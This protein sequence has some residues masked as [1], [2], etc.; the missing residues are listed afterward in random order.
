MQDE[1]EN[2]VAASIELSYAESSS[3]D[4]VGKRLAAQA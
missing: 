4:R 2:V 1:L 3:L